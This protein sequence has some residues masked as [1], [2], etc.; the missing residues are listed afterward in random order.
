MKSAVSSLAAL[1]TKNTNKLWLQ[2]ILTWATVAYH[3]GLPESWC[4]EHSYGL[5]LALLWGMPSK[6]WSRPAFREP[7]FVFAA[8]FSCCSSPHF[9]LSVGHAWMFQF[10]IECPATNLI[11]LD[12][13]LGSI[14]LCTVI[15]AE[16]LINELSSL[17]RLI[18][19]CTSVFI[20]HSC[21][22]PALLFL[23]MW[24]MKQLLFCCFSPSLCLYC[25]AVQYTVFFMLNPP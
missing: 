2:A 8:Q 20:A 1:L 21:V 11:L 7:F 3:C 13:H 19:S 23:Q 18:V 17:A 4:S 15:L 25:A 12:T 22:N 6:Q 16:R 5:P 24:D 9:F 14:D 10:K